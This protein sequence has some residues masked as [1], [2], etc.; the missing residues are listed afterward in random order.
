MTETDA[1]IADKPSARQHQ[2]RSKPSAITTAGMRALHVDEV[3]RARNMA[4]LFVV[5]TGT[6]GAWFLVLG[7]VTWL[8]YAA[9]GAC[10]GFGSVCA[11][12]WRRAKP[13]DNYRRLFRWFTSTAVIAS[14][15]IMY[16]IGVFSAS[17]IAVTLGISFFG[18]SHDRGWAIGS[19]VAASVIY[20]TTTL[21]IAVGAI[22]DLGL[23]RGPDSVAVQAFAILL[24]PIVFLGCLGQALLSRR[25]ALQA[26]AQVEEV[27]RVVQQRDAQLAEANLD[28]EKALDAGAGH[29][30]RHSGRR[31]G[32]WLLGSVI[33]RGAMGEVYAAATAERRA[34]VKTLVAHSDLDQLT[35]FRREAE[36]AQRV[37]S[38]GLVAVF[39]SGVLDDTVPYLVME[40]LEGHDLAWHLRKTGRLDLE[41]AR[42]LCDQIAAGLAAAHEAGIVHRDIKPQ[43]L[44][45]HEPA[46]QWKLLDFGVSKLTSSQGTLTQN[47]V[48]GTP[49]YMSPEQARGTEVDPRSDL[50]SLGAVLYRALTGQAPFHGSDTPQLL[51]DLCYRA[52]KRPTELAPQLTI[53]LDLFLAIALAKRPADRF[54]T[55]IELA[56]A[57]R[58]ASTD[59][60]DSALRRKADGLLAELPWGGRLRS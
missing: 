39:D 51:F 12:V 23:I 46:T 21:L 22:P 2:S 3:A 50:F 5:L 20:S 16:Y 28:L 31:A 45:L 25:T 13:D 19:C 38:P 43:N 27:A 4:R 56:E 40:L 24:V 11:Y 15:I 54:E 53:D 57:F 33:G 44:M 48:V 58:T 7:G 60:L 6:A 36:I 30:G 29:I 17:T 55:V 32:E 37:R 14:A 41:E 47:L 59:R 26:M 1:T 49:G 9:M 34:A 42:R 8:R 18:T 52:P 35:R 10:L